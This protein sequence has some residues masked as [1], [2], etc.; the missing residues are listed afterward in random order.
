MRIKHE[1]P[2]IAEARILD[3]ASDVPLKISQEQFQGMTMLL[4]EWIC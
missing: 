3:F 1:Y 2:E 4:Q